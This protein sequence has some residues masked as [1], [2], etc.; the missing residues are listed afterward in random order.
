M[1][2]DFEQYLRQRPP[3]L[4]VESAQVDDSLNFVETEAVFRTSLDFFRGHFPG[5]PIVPGVILLEAMAQSARL[6]LNVRAGGV[7]PGYLMA[8]DSLKLNGLVRPDE[9]LR[10]RTQLV[11][12]TD[13]SSQFKSS[14]FDVRFGKRCARAQL[15]LQ[16]PKDSLLPSC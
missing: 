16:Q 15:T 7:R 12:S 1:H 3:F 11:S 5:D 6:L 9:V 14:C 4:F 2:V 8:V 13:F 10:V